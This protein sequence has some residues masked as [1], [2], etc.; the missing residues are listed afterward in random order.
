MKYGFN[1][2]ALNSGKC[3]NKRKRDTHMQQRHMIQIWEDER[4]WMIY[5]FILISEFVFFFFFNLGKD[6]ETWAIEERLRE[7]DIMKI[8]FVPI[9]I[10]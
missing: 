2:C 4:A 5:P 6:P 9:V 10:S 1:W 7:K 3:L 8:I